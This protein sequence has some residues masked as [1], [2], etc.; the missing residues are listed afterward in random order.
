MGFSAR[1]AAPGQSDW[2]CPTCRLAS[3]ARGGLFVVPNNP[4]IVAAVQA[5]CAAGPSARQTEDG[6]RQDRGGAP[7]FEFWSGSGGRIRVRVDAADVEAAWSEVRAVSALTLDAAIALL[8]AL[9]ADPFR[10]AT[11]APRRDA[12]WLGAPAVLNAK[13]YRRFGAERN[14]FAEAVDAEIARLLKL[15][16]DIINYPAFDPVA[17][18]WRRTGVSRAGLT[19][20]ERAPEHAPAD[21]HDCSRG[22]P[23]RFGAWAEHWL[24]AGGPM[25]ASPLPQAL[26]VLDHRDSRGADLLAKKIGL[27][28]ALNWGAARSRQFIRLELRTLL[29]RVGELRRPGAE[30]AHFAG[31]LADRLEEALLRLSEN[32][33]VTSRLCADA[34]AARRATGRRWFEDWLCSEV[35]FDRPDFIAPSRPDKQ[36]LLVKHA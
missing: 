25:W 23:L 1:I 33:I 16:L 20:F 24:N 18:S 5:L 9:A 8:A 26:V 17:R 22:Q 2:Q 3:R 10:Q 21:P 36:R 14:Q 28:L 12:V 27:L 30:G 6:W 15:R 34:A 19:L 29:R 11:C 7:S 13:R 4:L 31:R 32:E 35:V